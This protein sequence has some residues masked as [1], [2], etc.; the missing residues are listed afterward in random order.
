MSGCCD[1]HYRVITRY[2]KSIFRIMNYFPGYFQALWRTFS[3]TILGHFR[4]SK[5]ETNKIQGIVGQ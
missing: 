2:L 3:L 1:D 5:E 4:P